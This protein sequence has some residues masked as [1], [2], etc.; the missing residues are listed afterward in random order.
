M[1]GDAMKR[2]Y[3]SHKEES[4]EAVRER[5]IQGISPQLKPELKLSRPCFQVHMGERKNRGDRNLGGFSFQEA[6]QVPASPPF[7]L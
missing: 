7:E 3:Y 2:F 1:N 6:P 5:E 4:P